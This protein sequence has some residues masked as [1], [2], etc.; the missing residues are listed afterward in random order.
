MILPS[1]DHRTFS[2][3]LVTTIPT[4]PFHRTVRGRTAHHAMPGWPIPARAAI[5][6][7]NSGGPT[8]LLG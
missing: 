6:P 3:R 5:P 4:M 1:W 8:I 2:T 7:V